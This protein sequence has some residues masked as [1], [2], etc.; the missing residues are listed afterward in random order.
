MGLPEAAQTLP[1]DVARPFILSV[2]QAFDSA[3]FTALAIA[4]ALLFGLAA[5][6][7]TMHRAGA[8]K[9]PRNDRII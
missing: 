7:W 8:W 5:V 3:Y 1:A 2:H 4:A 9:C 6:G